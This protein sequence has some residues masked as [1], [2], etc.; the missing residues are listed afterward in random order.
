VGLETSAPPNGRPATDG[1]E[2]APAE[3]RGASPQ[4]GAEPAE[5]DAPSRELPKIAEKADD[6]EAIKQAVDDAAAVGGGLW[7]SYL[8]VLFYL[9]VA[10]GAVTHADLFFEN[11]VKLPFLNVELPLLAFFFLAPILFLVV[12]AYTLVHLVMLTDKAKRFDQALRDQIG[13]A[14]A[15]VRDSLRR[16]LPSNI[17]IQ[18]LAGPADVRQS[19]FG[20]LLRA[21]AW[22][23]LVIAPVLLL[24]L[25]QIQFLPFHNSFITWTHRLAL[26]A[27]L[28]L[29]WWLWRKI[30]SGREIDGC[31][32]RA[33][34][35]WTGLGLTLSACA[36]LFSWAA[37]TFPGE[38]QEDHLPDWQI[39]LGVS[40][41][42]WG[43]NSEVDPATSRRWLPL[44]STLVLAGLNIYEGLAIDDPEKA[45]WRDFVFRAR[46][47]DLRGAIFDF[48]SLPK[49]DFAGAQLQ[50][51]ELFET[52]LQGASL[53]GA[54][55]QGASLSG[56]RLEGAS[57][58]GAQLQSASLDRAQL[59]GASLDGAQLQ[60]AS[61]DGAQLQGA[62]LNLA[63][64]QGVSLSGTRL[65]G[66]SLGGAQLQ[67]ASLDGAQLQGASLDGTQLQGASLNRAQLQGASL[68]QAQLQAT[69]LSKALLW[70]TNRAANSTTYA[71]QLA[72]VTLP[73]SDDSWLP[74][75]KGGGKV[76][77][78]NDDFYRHLREA[79]DSLSPNGRRDQ[80]LDRIRS[81]DCAN[82]DPTLASC[83]PT[84]PP[85]AEAASW[86][87]ALEDARVEDSAYAKVLAAALKRL[88]CS[89]E[90]NAAD[91]LR[92]LLKN[93]RLRAAGQEAPAL[94]DFIMSKDCPVSG[95]LTDAGKAN[96]LRT[97]QKAIE[98]PG[99]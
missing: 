33:G 80:A 93:G 42:D 2:A 30:L 68:Q 81:L 79:I 14:N 76:Q 66:A 24:L 74:V 97:K 62:T 59:Q 46:R 65:E 18:F 82:P 99:G 47:R 55:L 1:G 72:A 4:P 67:G 3:A 26:L 22:S 29:V 83:D 23:T 25:M 60:G 38:W 16:Q 52:E 94:V 89:G 91:V 13:D 73:D 88:V 48:A 98:K 17:F 21:I 28:T 95:S 71:A 69:D 63:E 19:P 84:L 70:R 50:D 57:L 20:W 6:L 35:A 41:H 11:P 92:G 85:P 7:L 56:A 5:T 54:R 53:Q 51:A 64:L 34:W 32:R 39:F 9:A 8:F 37:A 77:P 27:D 43:F 49:V 58:G 61:L 12:H 31:R 90:D 86:R 45:K 96:L 10:A 15:E 36:V 40:L 78:W 75:W 44:S 87:K